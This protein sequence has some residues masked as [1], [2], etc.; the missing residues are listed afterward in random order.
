MCLT[1]EPGIESHEVLVHHR[2]VGDVLDE[3]LEFG[4]IG[5]FTEEQQIRYLEIGALLGELID[6]IT[7]VE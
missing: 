4:R 1:R 5:K 6:R 7:A 3:L 2:V